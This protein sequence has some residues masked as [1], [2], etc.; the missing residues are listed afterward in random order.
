MKFSNLAATSAFAA[1]SPMAALAQTEA[2]SK[3]G[4]TIGTEASTECAYLSPGCSSRT[5]GI[6]LRAKRSWGDIVLRAEKFDEVDSRHYVNNRTVGYE[7]VGHA[8][9]DGAW[10]MQVAGKRASA[11]IIF[12]PSTH[13]SAALGVYVGEATG[14]ANH[15]EYGNAQMR[16][17]PSKL[18]G[19]VT[20]PNM[21]GVTVPSA[22]PANLIARLPANLQGPAAILL[23]AALQAAQNKLPENWA[24]QLPTGTVPITLPAAALEPQQATYQH[25]GHYSAKSPFGGV[26]QAFEYAPHVGNNTTL[27]FG[28]SVR[29]GVEGAT[30]KAGVGVTYRSDS[31]ASLTTSPNGACN[32]DVATAS[33]GSAFS[34]ALCA[35][36]MVYAP[37]HK[38]LIEHTDNAAARASNYI[39]QA[40]GRIADNNIP[41]SIPHVTG[42]QVRDLMQIQDPR[43]VVP[44]VDVGYAYS[45]GNF[46]VSAGASVP[47]QRDLKRNVTG[48][49]KAAYSF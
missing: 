45:T 40:N 29:A 2:P 43:K 18:P 5:Q 31:G 39:D 22:V 44:T 10:D 36:K 26:T 34:F 19:S 12:K 8:T 28:Q 48:Q 38:K 9:L 7:G 46:T 42:Q 35:S 32:G 24:S 14:V 1:L 15:R 30:V 3:L 49:V 16:I 25:N 13:T 4:V 11:E 21:S 47:L 23:P 20:M 33:R 27:R 41:L 6:S 17:D 37:L